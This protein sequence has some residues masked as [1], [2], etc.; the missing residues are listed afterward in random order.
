MAILLNSPSMTEFLLKLGKKWNEEC[1]LSEVDASGKAGENAY[2][3]AIQAKN[4]AAI[5]LLKH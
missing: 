3:V 2:E 5:V 1:E 4:Q